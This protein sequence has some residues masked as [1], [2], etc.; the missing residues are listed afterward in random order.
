[1]SGSNETTGGVIW[2]CGLA[3]TGKSTF[4]NFV[5][6]RFQHQA[7][8]VFAIDGD[9]FRRDVMPNAGYDRE[10]RLCVAAAI[11]EQAWRKANEGF[12]CV[13][14]T[15]SLMREIHDLNAERAARLALPLRTVIVTAP[16]TLFKSKRC[17]LYGQ[18]LVNVVGESIPAEYP[19]ELALNVN[20]TGTLSDLKALACRWVDEICRRE[21]AS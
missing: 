20:N 11:S 19:Q 6:E 18:A 7:L 15:I 3:G 5:V 17:E 9:A 4:A 10:S 8:P 16:A 1:M 21:Y 2:V 13:V 12:Q 14:S